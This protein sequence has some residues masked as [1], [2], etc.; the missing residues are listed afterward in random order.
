MSARLG[1]DQT[2]SRRSSEALS[3]RIRICRRGSTCRSVWTRIRYAS[4]EEEAY[5]IL[6]HT[7]RQVLP[8]RQILILRL[9]ASED[10]LEMVWSSP[11]RADMGL[12]SYPVWD[13]PSNC[14]VI[15]SGREYMVKDLRHDLTCSF[16]ISNE[17]DGAYWCVPL[18]IGGRTIGVVHLVSSVTHAW[19]Q[20]TS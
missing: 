11:K 3:L 18:V 13:N 4:S 19:T 5:R 10:R 16:S 20:D 2:I 14:P 15:R 7:L 17:G 6:V 12:N 9:N 1:D 8:L